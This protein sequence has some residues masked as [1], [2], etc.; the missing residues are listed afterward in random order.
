MAYV[1]R[2][3]GV[4]I[5][6]TEF[7]GSKIREPGMCVVVRLDKGMVLVRNNPNL[8]YISKIEKG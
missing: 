8:V 5:D 7:P 4:S 1:G 2:V 6:V 3:V